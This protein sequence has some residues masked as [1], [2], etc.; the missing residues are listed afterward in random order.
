[1]KGSLQ[2]MAVA[3]LIQLTCQDRKAAHVEI[4]SGRQKAALFFKNGNLVHAEVDD[5]RG[6]DAV[7]R[8]LGWNEGSFVL[9]PDVDPPSISITREWTS[10]LLEGAR[11]LDEGITSGSNGSGSSEEA[12][13]L[14]SAAQM[15]AV[16]LAPNEI[17]GVIDPEFSRAWSTE[18]GY[19]AA[20]KNMNEIQEMVTELG[21][22]TEGFMGVAVATLKGALLV[23]ADFAELDLRTM[24]RSLS[25]FV[26]TVSNATTKLGAGK[27][28]DNLLTTEKSYM[29]VR[30]LGVSS[31]YLLLIVDKDMANLG[32]LRHLSK[33]YAERLVK[34][35]LAV[36]AERL[37]L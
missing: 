8:L 26:K 17:A 18:T 10:L 32:N 16:N 22:Q 20:V 29:L 34:S 14:F 24:T 30:L 15:L 13:E 1:M 11:R 33:V 7:Y 2:D 23:S 6:E 28:E 3:D 12:T 19:S 9:K 4:R 31:V 25:Q 27:L 35:G 21:H 5:L 36:T 37:Q